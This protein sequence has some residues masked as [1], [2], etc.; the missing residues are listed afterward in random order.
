MCEPFGTCLDVCNSGRGSVSGQAGCSRAGELCLD[1]MGEPPLLVNQ[2]GF[3]HEGTA[4]E[5][6]PCSPL[7]I[8]L[9]GLDCTPT[10]CAQPPCD[11]VWMRS[12]QEDQDCG[13]DF[14]SCVPVWDGSRRCSR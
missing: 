14:P 1:L 12:C 11:T 5:G 9:D 13:P 10:S 7:G 2:L 8:F 6:D 3:C 4:T